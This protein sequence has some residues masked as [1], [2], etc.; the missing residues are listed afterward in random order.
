MIPAVGDILY[1][2]SSAIVKT[3]IREPESAALRRY[4]RGTGLHASSA[5]ARTEVP[6]AVRRS[7]P[8]ALPRA[9]LA[10]NDLLLIR[11]TDR[12]LADAGMVGPAELRALDAIHI[13][14]A[15]T[16]GSRLRAFVTYDARMASAAGAVGILV[17]APA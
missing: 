14:T 16:T 13:V 5:I 7:D 15:L 11:L 2:D 9:H 12:V 6:R 17:E 4:L 3:V 10:L 1:L 8:T